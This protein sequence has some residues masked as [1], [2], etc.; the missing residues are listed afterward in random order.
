MDY[1]TW[2]QTEL[3]CSCTGYLGHPFSK[4]IDLLIFLG[5]MALTSEGIQEHQVASTPGQQSCGR[6]RRSSLFSI[7]KHEGYGAG[8]LFC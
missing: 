1:I 6:N 3:Q 7:N 8:N 2:S 4:P 5:A